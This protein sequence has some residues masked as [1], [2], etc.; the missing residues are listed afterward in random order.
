MIIDFISLLLQAIGGGLASSAAGDGENPVV[1]TNIMIA[2][3]IFQLVS[4]V[5][6]TGLMGLVLFRGWKVVRSDKNLMIISSATIL[7]VTCVV[8]RGIYRSIELLQGWTGYLITNERFAL[9]LDGGMIIL[10]VVIFN[11]FNPGYLFKK[12]DVQTQPPKLEQASDSK[13]ELQ[14]D[15]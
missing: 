1:G 3:I 2:G 11:V 10:A 5:V 6:F 12:V 8:I 15:V 9:A 13:Q 4:L 14:Q 7:S